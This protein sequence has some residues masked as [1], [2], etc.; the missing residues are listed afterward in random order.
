LDENNLTFADAFKAA[1]DIFLYG[2]INK[3]R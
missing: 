3:E 2:I 1:V